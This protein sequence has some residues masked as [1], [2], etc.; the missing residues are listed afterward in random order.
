VNLAVAVVMH[1]P[2]IREI[3]RTP[4]FLGNH[5]MHVQVFAVFQ[6]LVTDGTE[7]LLS[8][9]QLPQASGRG[10]DSA[11]PLFPVGLKGWVVGG[12][13]GGDEPMP[14]DPQTS[15]HLDA[16]IEPGALVTAA[17]RLGRVVP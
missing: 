16:C 14:D 6:D 2:E 9:G 3:I 5:M 7:A 1:Q 17:S 13:G 10:L 11:L 15:A 8:P 4:V 12:I